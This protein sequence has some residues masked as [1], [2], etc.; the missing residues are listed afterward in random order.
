VRAE[1]EQRQEAEKKRIAG[2][3]HTEE[4]RLQAARAAAAATPTPTA[5]PT[6]SAA[7]S[8]T[9]V[10]TAVD[11]P[12]PATSEILP[13]S[14][15]SSTLAAAPPASEVASP[16]PGPT[17]PSA[18]GAS[19]VHTVGAPG[20]T[21]PVL[22]K[23]APVEYPQLAKATRVQGAVVVSALVDEKGR[24]TEARAVSPGN[25][26]LRQAAVAHVLQRQYVPGQKDGVPVKV[27]ILVHVSFKF[28]N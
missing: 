3:M 9:A 24:V 6:S 15:P 14:A 12:G 26:I 20:V 16:G 25:E 2:E 18:P 23:S 11:V 17:A 13:S 27:R 10:A 1:Q 28:Q 19:A 8:R 5:A 7:A 4:A 21:A 22:Q